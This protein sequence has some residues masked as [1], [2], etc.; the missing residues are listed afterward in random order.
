MKK[1]KQPKVAKQKV[2]AAAKKTK[3]PKPKAEA[4]NGAKSKT[5]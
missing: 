3:E 1:P 4:K 5:D 2:K